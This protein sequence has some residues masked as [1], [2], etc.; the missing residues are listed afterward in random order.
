M[1][2]STEAQASTVTPAA[3]TSHFVQAGKVKL[4]YIDY[5]TAGK[6][7]MLC[8]HGGAAHAHWFDYVAPAFRRD[9]HV[10]S[11]DLRGHGDSEHVD[12]PKYFYEDYAADVNAF[13]EALDLKDFVL[14]GHSMGGMVSLVYSATYPG[15]VKKLVVVDTSVNLPPERIALLRDVGSKPPRDYDSREEMVSRYKL[16]PGEALAPAEVVRYIG[17]RSIKETDEG[18]WRYKFDR[19]VYSTRE[20][21][22]GMPLWDDIRIPALLVKADRSPRITQEIYEQAKA[23]SSRVEFVEISN[24][25]HHITL[26]NPVE[27]VDKV[28]PFLKK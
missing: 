6:P 23:R 27:F 9:Y 15:R 11:L 4:H 25:D 20:P 16:R 26:D 13:V 28:G 17:E 10:L 12:P 14:I 8:I 7:V 24:S 21:K 1:Q 22:D 2:P 5:G 19:A 18:K 3:Y